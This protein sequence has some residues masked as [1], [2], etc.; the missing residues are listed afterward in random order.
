MPRPPAA[1]GTATVAVSARGQI[2]VDGAA[3]Q[4]DR[5][6]AVGNP[7]PFSEP[8]FTAGAAPRE[9]ATHGTGVH[10]HRAELVVDAAAQTS[11]AARAAHGGAAGE[12]AVGER[13]R[14]EV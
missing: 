11:P 9:I 13:Q 12:R 1:T 10:I 3:V 6:R 7:A 14:A 5:T 8:P 4:F 2:A